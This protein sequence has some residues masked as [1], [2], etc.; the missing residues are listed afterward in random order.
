MNN[1][2]RI[3][4][5][6]K[7]SHGSYVDSYNFK[8]CAP[9]IQMQTRRKMKKVFAGVKN[10]DHAGPVMSKTYP[11]QK[12][13]ISIH[14]VARPVEQRIVRPIAQYLANSS[15]LFILLIY[16]KII[17]FNET[18]AILNTVRIG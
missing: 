16:D 2:S 6:A 14:I 8:Y 11:F 4:M 3:E 15:W 18:P 9:S 17:I 12:A 7:K 13:P 10:R 1:G 5:Y